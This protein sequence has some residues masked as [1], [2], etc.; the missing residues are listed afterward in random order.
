M[1]NKNNYIH[2]QTDPSDYKKDLKKFDKT[3]QFILH[4]NPDESID[5]TNPIPFT[6]LIE[7]IYKSLLENSTNGSVHFLANKIANDIIH[8]YID[9]PGQLFDIDDAMILEGFDTYSTSN[10][11]KYSVVSDLTKYYIQIYYIDTFIRVVKPSIP[12]KKKKNSIVS[13]KSFTSESEN[14]STDFIKDWIDGVD[15]PQNIPEMSPLSSIIDSL[16]SIHYIY[17]N[18]LDSSIDIGN[19]IEQNTEFN[20]IDDLFN[21]SSKKTTSIPKSKSNSYNLRSGIGSGNNES[22]F[23]DLYHRESY[24][25]YDSYESFSSKKTYIL[26]LPFIS[27]TI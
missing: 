6:Y 3:L 11:D 16:K 4:N 14:S 7:S 13:T 15:K 23:D 19:N 25:P 1:M 27:I 18:D 2:L 20:E 5:P 24:N 8:T 10:N 21:R 9:H 26:G 17:K 12:K 22:Y